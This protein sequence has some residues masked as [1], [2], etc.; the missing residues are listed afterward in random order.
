MFYQ[1]ATRWCLHKPFLFV[2]LLGASLFSRAQ[3]T[4][5]LFKY[6]EVMSDVPVARY[7]LKKGTNIDSLPSL[8]I[9]ARSH[10]AV[11]FDDGRS[12]DVIIR[13]LKWRNRKK[14]MESYHDS[15]VLV[16]EG[17]TVWGNEYF[18]LKRE[19]FNVSTA[20]VYT[21][22]IPSIGFALGFVTMPVK[23]RTGENYDFEPTLSLGA[24]A[25]A[26]IRLSHHYP[27][28]LNI[29]LGASTSTVN[30]DSFSTRGAIREVIKNILVFS[31]SVGVVLEFSKAQIGLFF[32][33]D[34]MGKSNNAKYNWIYQ[35]KPWITL[36]F[37]FTIFTLNDKQSAE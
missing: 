6:Y 1:N 32:G 28:Y 35:G 30:I 14:T 22:G 23:I 3:E 4:P 8:I 9:P 26:K 29:L 7:D 36:G 15:V 24:T 13:F 33:R 37:G 16:V 19:F 10:F 5:D 34:L 20:R 18:A 12:P 17:Q 31:T 25:G 27:N 21:E 11:V 2:F